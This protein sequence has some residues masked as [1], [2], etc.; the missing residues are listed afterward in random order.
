VLLHYHVQCR[1]LF[2]VIIVIVLIRTD[3]VFLMVML[4][5][6]QFSIKG[7]YAGWLLTSTDASSYCS[8]LHRVELSVL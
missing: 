8:S 4:S 5:L 3:L 1:F 2:C 6:G 7:L